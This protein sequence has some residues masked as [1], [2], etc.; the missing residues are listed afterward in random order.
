MKRHLKWIVPAII[1]VVAVIV[2]QQSRRGG[3]E[4]NAQGG[5]A[6]SEAILGGRTGTCEMGEIN[7]LLT[8]V[9]EIQPESMVLVKSK[10]SG[11]IVSLHVKEGENVRKGQLLAKVEPDMA[12]ARTVASL[13]SGYG[14]A[15][16]DMDRA[17]QDYERDLEL[18]NAGHI[19]DE[20]LRLSK[21]DYDIAKIEY[22]SALEQM[23]LAEEDGVS[24]DLEAESEELLDVVSP[25]SGSVIRVDVEEGEIVTS[26][27]VSYTSGTTLMTV[28]DL[29]RMQIK[30]GV[31]EV[32]VGKIRFGQDVVI[33]VDAYPNVK[34]QGVI[35]H[36]AP[37][38]R[39]EQG[40]KIFDVDI[41]IVDSDERLRPGMTANIE[42]Q[43]DHKTDIL[44]VPVEAVF[45]KQG[46]YV[47]YVFDGS[48][49]EPVEREVM[50]GISNIS[51]V[52]IIAGLSEGD[53]VALYDPE[54]E[55]GEMSEDEQRRQRM[56]RG[57][58]G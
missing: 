37:A 41:D 38:A 5:P 4:A 3:S 50:T 24:M 42:I 51:S 7:V 54:L 15:R 20:E 1:V 28:A 44:T 36:I 58:R 17:R 57:G 26:G 48:E 32:D 22:Q 25:A 9:G 23:K 46:R 11:K 19:S 34:Y 45:K 21:D 39:D 40:V 35:T 6:Q 8:E 43:G 29:S 18:H 12:Q 53:R 31:N 30:A 14:R 56:A 47:A 27:A 52:E 10:V 16:V 2:F 33:D 55:G 13:K 49:N